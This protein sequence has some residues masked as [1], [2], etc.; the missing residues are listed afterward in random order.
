MKKKIQNG[1]YQDFSF[2]YLIDIKAADGL[3]KTI[4]YFQV[5]EEKKHH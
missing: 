2:K 5:C 3:K 4:W 1:L